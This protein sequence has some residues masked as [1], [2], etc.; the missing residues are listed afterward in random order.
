MPRTTLGAEKPQS[1]V[2][3]NLVVLAGND[4]AICPYEGLGL[5]ISLQ[6]HGGP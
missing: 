3:R 1:T 2:Q 6:N 4:P 5:P